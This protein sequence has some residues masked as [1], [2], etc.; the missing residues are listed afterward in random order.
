MIPQEDNRIET[1]YEFRG[2]LARNRQQVEQFGGVRCHPS[3]RS[4]TKA[5]I[6][7]EIADADVAVPIWQAISEMASWLAPRFSLARSTKCL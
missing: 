1:P 3:V 5:A 2:F 7:Y 6:G 4:R